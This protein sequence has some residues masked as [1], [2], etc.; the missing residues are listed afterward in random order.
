MKNII[1]YT[2][3]Y[4]GYDKRNLV[5]E[6]YKKYSGIGNDE[7]DMEIYFISNSCPSAIQIGVLKR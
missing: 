6:D 1:F 3:I 7:D 5:F 4:D 2:N